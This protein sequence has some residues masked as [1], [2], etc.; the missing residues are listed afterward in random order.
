LPRRVVLKDSAVQQPANR[1]DARANPVRG[2]KIVFVSGEPDTPGHH[3][4]VLRNVAA[5]ASI[6]AD[7]QWI[8]IADVQEKL[9]EIAAAEIT[10]IWRVPWSPVLADVMRV[11]R[12]SGAKVVYD[13]DD[14]MF[15]RELASVDMI[16][17]IRSQRL[18]PVAVTELFDDTLRA[19][20]AADMCTCPTTEI[21]LQIRAFQTPAVV[22]PNGFDEQLHR[23]A[24]LAVRQRHS[25]GEQE[26]VRIGY[27][28]GSRTHQR[29]FAI[30][31]DVIARVLRERPNCRLVLFRRD[32][33]PLIDIEEYPSL[34][35]VD[36]QIEWRQMRPLDDLPDELVRFDVNLAP[37]E[38]GNPFCEAKSELK[39]FEAALVDVCTIAS[40]TGPFRRT[41]RDGETGFLATTPQEW[42]QCLVE[43]VDDP[44]RRRKIGHAAYL[45][46]LWAYGP[47]RRAENIAA[48]MQQL[49]GG[50]QAAQ[51]LELDLFRKTSR[52][53]R[54]PQFPDLETV[55]CHDRLGQ[56]EVCVVIPLHNYAQFVGEALDSVRA[57]SLETIDLIVVDDASTDDSLNVA[58]EWARRYAERFNRMLVLRN[59]VNA[60]L[61]L[62]RNAGID[63]A[64]APFVFLLDADNRLLRECCDYCLRE[65]RVSDA[66]FAYPQIQCFGDSDELRGMPSFEPMRLAGGNYIDAMAMFAKWSWA[67]VGGFNRHVHPGWEDYDFW[68]NL[69]EYGFWG[70][71]VP[72]ILAEYRVHSSSMLHRTTDV[73]K[74]KRELIAELEGRH[75]WLA[76]PFGE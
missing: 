74:N 5:A 35:A 64:E 61:A 52:P 20:L 7:V 56:A 19:L 26:L 47:L 24:R 76:I 48:L 27:A 4:R 23:L 15:R 75:P 29:D 65:L 16:D 45:A 69:V 6:G 71:Q 55:F 18:D 42:Y 17:G 44:A 41:I 46:V 40:P 33:T 57:Q 58:T 21:A 25:L 73:A 68:C 34:V 12:K 2:L 32:D 51:A 31:A 66:A 9:Q 1:P 54:Q 63:A 11:A 28:A 59:R 14:L 36:R 53:V 70:I 72:H 67:A 8:S 37:L 49:E 38:V 22:L 50:A 3:Y 43:L 39:F 62:T 30:I 60:G 10:V 13:I